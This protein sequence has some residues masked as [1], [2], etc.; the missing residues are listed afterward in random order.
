VNLPAL[1]LFNSLFLLDG[2]AAIIGLLIIWVAGCVLSYS[3]RY[4]HGDRLYRQFYINVVLL[5]ISTLA[6]VLANHVAVLC[7]LWL[8]S[9]LLLVRLMIHKAQWQ[10]ARSAGMI[11]LAYFACG[12]L[13]LV[14]GFYFLCQSSGAYTIQEIIH[15]T[16]LTM[17]GAVIGLFM[18]ML[19]AFIQ[20]SIW[21]LHGWLLS[22]LN[23]PT[24][25]SAI[26][27][28]GLVN[29]GGILIIRLAPLY[30]QAPILLHLLFSAGLITAIAGIFW[31][32]MQP[33]VKRMLACSTIGQ[34]GFMMMQC[35]LGLFPAAVAHICWHGLFKA[36][37]F[38][39]SGSAAQEKRLDSVYTPGLL[40]FVTALGC[41]AA[42][43]YM[44]CLISGKP[45][46]HFDST[47]VLLC[48]ICIAG[49]QFALTLLRHR[50]ILMLPVALLATTA[51]GS[52]YGAS[53]HMIEIGLPAAQQAQPLAFNILHLYA[54]ALLALAWLAMLFLR[55]PNGKLSR[56]VL[57]GYVNALNASQPFASTITSH[58]NQ[59][60]F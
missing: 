32:L 20:S 56:F 25:V 31:K 54:M 41:G 58:R 5:G 27:H 19:A 21:P 51:M 30:L 59:Y 22:S 53:V 36:Y 55:K 16:D 39:S 6:M 18:I 47:L 50:P 33:D 4:L 29:G 60:R 52:F 38:L 23:S 34:M 57:Y 45:W 35:G 46:L 42:G 48:V 2:L 24:P 9:N 12:W 8:T 11:A 7:V 37:L 17:P 10:A 43:T 40:S 44:F 49:S 1:E 14:G 15:K 26:M 13:L 3:K 28:A